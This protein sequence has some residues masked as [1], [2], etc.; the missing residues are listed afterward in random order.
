MIPHGYFASAVEQAKFEL[1]GP[2]RK[3]AVLVY[4]AITV[5]SLGRYS[6]GAEAPEKISPLRLRGFMVDPPRTP[7]SLDYYRRLIAFSADWG[8]NALV[9]RIAD[10]QGAAIRFE[11][12]PEFFTHKNAL[13]PS[14]VRELVAYGQQRGVELIPEIESFG[15]TK[16]ITSIDQYAELADHDPKNVDKRSST[17]SGVIPSHPKVL[18]L[19]EDIYRETAA[20]FPSRY[21]HGGCDEVAWGDS[22]FTRQRLKS[23]SRA[24]IWAQYINDLNGIVRKAGKEFIIW[25]DHPL[26]EDPEIL[27]YLSK[28]IILMDWEYSR[29]D[30]KSVE[31]A[32]RKVLSNGMRV[33][34]APSLIHCKWGP[35]A[36][37]GQLRN[38][39]AYADAYRGIDDARNLGVMVTNWVPSRYIQNSIWDGVAYAG[40]ALNQG[41]AIARRD[42]FKRFVEKHYGG[43]WNDNWADIFDSYYAAAPDRKGCAPSWTW[44][45]LPAAWHN[46]EGLVEVLNGNSTYAPPFTRILSLLN[47]SEP[48]VRRNLSDFRSFRLSLRYLEQLYWRNTVLVQELSKTETSKES[49]AD[50]IRAI[51]ERDRLLYD[52]MSTEWDQGRPPESTLKSQDIY[53]VPGEQLVF[54]F[55]RASAYSSELAKNPDSFISLLREAKANAQ[56]SE[57]SLMTSAS[58]PHASCR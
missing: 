16:Y 14:E 22:D 48:L 10:D 27:G 38:I 23:K 1:R 3:C 56:V 50:L 15:H 49:A 20:L 11:S 42:G 55:G 45:K 29:T 8:F 57:P 31:T 36:G 5:L 30:P 9:F 2:I 32:A 34:G 26:N 37:V 47:F 21:L 17:F 6:R 19:F 44:P 51:A 28:D 53:G 58:A 35:R 4:L 12:H 54:D 24:Q 46:R 39:D 25:G 7:E 33:I 41:S 18:R 13:T 40:V 43:Q 52:E